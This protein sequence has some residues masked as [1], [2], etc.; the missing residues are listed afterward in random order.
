MTII[1]A[2]ILGAVQGITEFLPISSSGHLILIPKIL[3]WTESGLAFDLALHLGTLIAILIYLKSDL[4]GLITNSYKNKT[5]GLR[6]VLWLGIATI[7]IALFGF[8]GASLVNL[9]RTPQ[10]VSTM[11]IVWGI[12]LI[13]AELK[14]SFS[15]QTNQIEICTP[16]ASADPL[17][18]SSPPSYFTAVILGLAQAFALFP[19]TSR[20][21]ATITVGL[22]QGKLALPNLIRLSFLMAIPATIG[23]I[24][25]G[26]SNTNWNEISLTPLLIGAIISAIFGLIAMKL[27]VWL[28]TARKLWWFGVYRII[29]G[30]VIIQIL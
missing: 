16:L 28:G 20:S 27:L 2:V 21:G 18:L 9:H 12:L 8:F 4:I 13:L 11:L 30:L 23:A 10:V 26:W 22:L 24:L 19:G 1:Q 29:L 14:N 7:P 5:L 3:S 25:G 6:W 15:Q 17:K